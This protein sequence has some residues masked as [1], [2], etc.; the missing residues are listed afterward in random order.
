[1]PAL[2][3][4]GCEQALKR[5]TNRYYAL[6]HDL[7]VIARA[8]PPPPRHEAA[9]ARE[10][11]LREERGV[12]VAIGSIWRFLKANRITLKKG[13]DAGRARSPRC[14]GVSIGMARDAAGAGARCGRYNTL[15]F[16]ELISSRRRS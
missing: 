2:S 11:R 9:V 5:A 3:R 14:R 12:G 7:N 15:N 10:I 6:L 1:M 16:V 4:H 13:T 8:V